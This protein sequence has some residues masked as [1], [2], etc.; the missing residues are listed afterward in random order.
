L[1]GERPALLEPNALF[2]MV[3]LDRVKQGPTHLNH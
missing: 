2:T 1:R 3:M